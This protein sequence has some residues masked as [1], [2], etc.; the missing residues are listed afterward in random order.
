MV[1]DPAEG[2]G[3][4][5]VVVVTSQGSSSTSSADRFTYLGPVVTSV[6]PQSGPSAGGTTV[7]IKGTDLNGA[8]Q[9]MFGSTPVTPSSISG[10]GKVIKVVSP[11]GTGTVDIVV[12]TPGGDSPTTSADQYTY[13]GPT[14][15]G[16]RRARA[17]LSAAPN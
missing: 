6:S 9:V 10:N 7:T 12:D 11:A 13:V 5:D 17:P 4:V 15:T 16:S 3:T 2:A 14:V 1:R 8:T